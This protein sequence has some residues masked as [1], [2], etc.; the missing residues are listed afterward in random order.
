MSNAPEGWEE[1]FETGEEL[2]WQGRPDTSFVWQKSNISTALLGLVVTGFGVIWITI[3]SQ[4]GGY[5]WLLGIGF[6]L[7]GPLLAIAPPYMNALMRR[8]TWYSLS[9][10]RAFIATERASVGRKL[11]AYAIH[12]NFE[13]E[14][15]HADPATINFAH[16]VRYNGNS[17]YTVKIGFERIQD[18]QQVY[19]MMAAIQKGQL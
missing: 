5:F 19:D 8:A 14:F 15:D 17:P 3:T 6:L 9:N 16:E 18:G 12:P 4:S 11:R 13:L 2:L 10:K 7:I 1:I